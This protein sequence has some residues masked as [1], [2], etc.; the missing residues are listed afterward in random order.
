M[1]A[2]VLFPFIMVGIFKET[3]PALI[4]FSIL[5]AIMVLITHQ[6]NIERL[7]RREES[8]AKIIKKKTKKEAP[9]DV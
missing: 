6:K 4:I 9:S 5:I 7:L 3:V 1:S 2:A 8:K